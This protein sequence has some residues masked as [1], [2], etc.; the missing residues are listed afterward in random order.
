MRLMLPLLLL[1]S[2]LTACGGHI[3]QSSGKPAT[4]PEGYEN[5]CRDM[6][7]FPSCK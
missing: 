6:P 7:K 4:A 3:Y 5:L 1:S 2:V